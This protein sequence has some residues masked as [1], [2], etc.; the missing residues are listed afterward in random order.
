MYAH[1]KHIKSV[2]QL[3]NYITLSRQPHSLQ[4]CLFLLDICCRLGTQYRSRRLS[5]LHIR[6][7]YTRCNRMNRVHYI[8]LWHSRLEWRLHWRIFYL[9]NDETTVEFNSYFFGKPIATFHIM[10]TNSSIE[11]V[12]VL[13]ALVT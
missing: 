7:P 2:L 12:C 13:K 6:H 4:G 9:T 8:R 5:N 1:Y 10:K 3:F 11:R